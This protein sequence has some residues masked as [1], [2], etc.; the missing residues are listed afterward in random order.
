MFLK[1]SSRAIAATAAVAAGT[2]VAVIGSA[3]AS[4][5]DMPDV[6]VLKGGVPAKMPSEVVH[7]LQGAA[8]ET[9]LKLADARSL[10]GPHSGKTWHLV[11]TGDDGVCMVIGVTGTCGTAEAIRTGGFGLVTIAAPT[12]TPTSAEVQANQEA[13]EA[14]KA[15]GDKY[16]TLPPSAHRGDAVRRG[17]V[18]DGIIRVQAIGAQDEVLH[19]AEVEDNL[20]EL[21]LGKD[22]D[23][24][25][26][27]FLDV[28]GRSVVTFTLE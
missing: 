6:G 15:R 9:E 19:E 25:R 20:Y 7:M 3:V 27:A 5:A 2:A 13:L 16:V 12:G 1:K 11:P 21:P 28:T 17:I 14:A 10:T 26:V 22:G 24:E 18:E 23:T 8:P 4:T